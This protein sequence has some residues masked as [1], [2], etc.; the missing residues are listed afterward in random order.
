MKP[1]E[2]YSIIEQATDPRTVGKLTRAD[3]VN[4]HQALQVLAD[5]LSKLQRLE[6]DEARCAGSGAPEQAP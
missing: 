6:T 3:Y 2:A 5:C 4:I 1:L